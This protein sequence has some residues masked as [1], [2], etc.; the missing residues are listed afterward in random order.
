MSTCPFLQMCCYFA[1]KY[2]HELQH[3]ITNTLTSPAFV[4]F[5][6]LFQLFLKTPTLKLATSPA[7]LVV[8]PNLRLQV[9]GG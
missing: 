9:G 5:L 4:L 6:L 7:A 8:S 3:Y 2:E 1:R